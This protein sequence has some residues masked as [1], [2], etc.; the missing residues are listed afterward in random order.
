MFSTAGLV[1]NSLMRC[2]YVLTLWSYSLTAMIPDRTFHV[3]EGK[4]L[5]GAVL[6]WGSFVTCPPFMDLN[7]HLRI[8][9]GG[10]ALRKYEGWMDGR[11]DRQISQCY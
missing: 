7:G 5:Y 6:L 11:T 9:W 3:V 1:P 2:A 10:G 4:I 8:Y